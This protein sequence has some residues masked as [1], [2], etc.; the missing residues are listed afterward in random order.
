MSSRHPTPLATAP[1]SDS[2]RGG[3]GEPAARPAGAAPPFRLSSL[4][5][6]ALSLGLDA[7][8][9]N[10]W[11]NANVEQLRRVAARMAEIDRDKAL[12]A[13]ALL[14]WAAAGRDPVV[15]TIEAGKLPWLFVA[16]RDELVRFGVRMVEL[17]PEGASAVWQG[18]AEALE[19]R[20]KAIPRPLA[21]SA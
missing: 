8:A 10:A 15:P 16:P 19:E 6:G 21:D 18:L 5:Q 14:A 2:V 20:H 12:A 11:R 3:P 7:A 9:E 13:S 4:L 17:C 1:A